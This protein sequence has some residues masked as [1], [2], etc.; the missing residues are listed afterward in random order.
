VVD[1]S[2]TTN[3][4]DALGDGGWSGRAQSFVHNP[5]WDWGLFVEVYRKKHGQHAGRVFEL[6]DDGAIVHNPSLV[7]RERVRHR[8]RFGSSAKIV[9]SSLAEG[10]PAKAAQV[11]A[12]YS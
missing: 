7:G 4:S 9:F 11:H 1:S 5:L 3:D 10:R 2:S 8:E 12:R 6:L